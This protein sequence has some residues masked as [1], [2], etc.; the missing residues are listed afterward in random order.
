MMARVQQLGDEELADPEV[1]KAI[2]ASA[3]DKTGNTYISKANEMAALASLKLIFQ[4]V[5]E[6]FTVGDAVECNVGRNKWAKGKVVKLRYRDESFP[7]GLFA[8]YQIQLDK[9]EGGDLIYAPCD[10]QDVIRAS[11]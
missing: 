8:P 11:S 9:S 1:R 7:P 5:C 2:M 10:E 4:D 6:G 3:N